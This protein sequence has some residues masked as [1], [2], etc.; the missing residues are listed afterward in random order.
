VRIA[1]ALL[2][3]AALVADVVQPAWALGSGNGTSGVDPRYLAFL[4]SHPCGFPKHATSTPLPN[5]TSEVISADAVVNNAGFIPSIGQRMKILVISPHAQRY[6]A[7]PAASAAD[8]QNA[9]PA[10]TASASAAPD[11]SAAPSV[12]PDANASPQA[13]YAPVTTLSSAPPGAYSSAPA[14]TSGQ[15]ASP[16]A[17]ATATPVPIPRVPPG[18]GN[19]AQLVPPTPYSNASATPTPQPLPTT[20][21]AASAGPV[22]LER[23]SPPPIT[24]KGATPNPNA[25][26]TASAA[27]KPKDRPTLSPDDVV[28][29]ADH[30]SGSTDQ[31]QPSDLTGNVHIFYQEGQI[32][33]DRAHYDG[34]HTIVVSG[35]TY[36]INRAQD[37]ILYGDQIAF[38]TRTRK[39]VLLNGSG[40]S[41]EAVST[42]KLHYE[43]RTLNARADGV[44]HGDRASFTTCENGHAGY[45]IEARTIDVTP[46]DKLVARKAVLYLGPTAILY[47]PVLV[48][49]LVAAEIGQRTTSFIPLIGYDST[50]GFFIKTRIGFGTTKTY[51][52][53]YRVEYFTKR[54]LGL[55]YVGYIG[56]ADARRY[57]TI[58]AYTI[59]DHVL[60]ERTTNVNIQDVETFTQRLRGQFGVTYVGDFGPGISLPASENITGSLIHTG[61]FS[62]E[63]LT[64][65]R[66]VQGNLSDNLNIGLTDMLT[67]NQQLTQQF[68]FAYAKFSSELSSTD[69]FHIESIT[70]YATKFA[71]YNLTYDKTDYSSDPFGYDRLPELQVLPHINYGSFK[72]GPQLQFTGG[73]YAEDQNHFS[74]SRFQG[75][76][77]E[78]VT[79]KVFG[80][81]DFNAN[82]NLTQDYYG[83]GDEKAFDQQNA[84]LSTPIGLHLIN[85]ITYNE[86]HP[87]GPANVP[88]QL[89]DNLSSGAHSAQDVLRFYNGD[90]YSFSIS[91]GTSFNRQAQSATYQLNYRPSPK[92]Y[93]V[94]GGYFQPG[95]GQGFGTTNVQVITPFGK[96]TSLQFSTNVDWKNHNRLEDKNIYL[97]KTVDNCYNLLASYN[98]DLKAFS[99]SIVILAFPGQSVGFGL[100]GSQSSPILP[101]SFAF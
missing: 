94:I 1:T 24:A 36:L 83:T 57:T 30:L 96:D 33:G 8:V 92:S 84:S 31:S 2:C 76:L 18:G 62:T 40:E 56:A 34:D 61:N 53:Y 88:F 81:S 16:A 70:H 99:F 11:A 80:D 58:D 15:S 52:G 93:L 43:A 50:D 55:G 87:I 49:P 5:M 21:S 97:S 86:Q 47:L 44:S 41:S 101:Q 22:F 45:H 64:F 74:T 79:E 20:S 67:I 69:T 17:T 13:S 60:N 29:I 35:H 85:S 32:V 7:S 38:D 66:Y 68:N 98:Q 4:K 54:G 19:D 39:A 91:D 89:L 77:N 3:V 46:S 82:Y 26:A 65:S 10:P 63:N 95:P 27:P 51:Y 75:Q 6:A 71:D 37:S 28:T 9:S 73:E 14:D 23:S 48:I 100:G 72:F 59:K 90:V 25:S 42:G 78:A 12:A